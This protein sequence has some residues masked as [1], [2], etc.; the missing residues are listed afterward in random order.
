MA[1]L[2]ALCIG[3]VILWSLSSLM[4]LGYHDFHGIECSNLFV[5]RQEELSQLEVLSRKP[6]PIVLHGIGGVGKTH[7]AKQFGCRWGMDRSRVI[8]SST[9]KQL[10]DGIMDFVR[11]RDQL[12][13]PL[14]RI[15]D[16]VRHRDRLTT[17]L[18]LDDVPN[19]TAFDG[20]CKDAL[21]SLGSV[22]LLITSRSAAWDYEKVV[23]E[24][25]EG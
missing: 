22:L 12:T 1:I 2:C 18:I 24:Q 25:T 3:F 9:E 4:R 19:R 11:H 10:C 14:I 15:M 7:L 20:H 16:F 21:G 13:T 5:G 8:P 17:L 23:V 6:G